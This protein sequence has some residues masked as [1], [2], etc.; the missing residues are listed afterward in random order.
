[1]VK[2]FLAFLFLFV[3]LPSVLCEDLR[4]EESIIME[5]KRNSER[6]SSYICK[7]RAI[8]RLDGKDLRIEGKASFTKG[9]GIR[10][11]ER[12]YL[13]G[14]ISYRK[15]LVVNRD[16]FWIYQENK[17]ICYYVDLQKLKEEFPEF[18]ERFNVMSKYDL[19]SLTE[20][21]SIREGSLSWIGEETVRGVS[22]YIFE[23]EMRGINPLEEILK[24][25]PVPGFRKGRIWVEKERGVIR[26]VVLYDKAGDEIYSC[27]F[28]QIIPKISYE[29]GEYRFT[30]PLGCKILEL[31]EKLRERLRKASNI[32]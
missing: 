4:G 23:A 15:L 30:P 5:L 21:Y 20:F 8:L 27:T 24:G 31:T 29:A 19:T 17:N 22:T 11:K 6:L 7:Y 13:S 2:Y 9:R 32:S 12:V 16:E 10:A 25:K 1:M 14:S 18:N 3:T 26:R 28:T